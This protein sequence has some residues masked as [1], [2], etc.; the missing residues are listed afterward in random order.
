MIIHWT[1]REKVMT[2]K[3]SKWA[4][5]L[6]GAACV[7]CCTIPIIGLVMAGAGSAALLGFF[8]SD[9]FKEI[10]I[11]GIPLL[12]IIIGFILFSRRQKAASCCNTPTSDCSSNQCGIESNKN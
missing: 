10:L 1:N 5:G 9:Q 4:I 2:D 3:K 12:L 7:A 6:V 8:A 11:C